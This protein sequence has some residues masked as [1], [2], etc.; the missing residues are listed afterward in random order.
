MP[1]RLQIMDWNNV[2]SFWEQMAQSSLWTNVKSR[3]NSARWWTRH[4]Q[5][6]VKI[7]KEHWG[8]L[9][10]DI[11]GMENTILIILQ[12]RVNIPALSARTIQRDIAES[13][14]TISSD[15]RVL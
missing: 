13:D 5:P 4:V 7:K 6:S 2:H 1:Q 11:V 10:P 8:M 9:V 14:F 3:R 15:I 12:A